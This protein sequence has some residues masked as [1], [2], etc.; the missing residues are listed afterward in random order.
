M[1]L[2]ALG[3]V[4]DVVV[5]IVTKSHVDDAAFR[6]MSKVFY[7][8]VQSQP[9]LDAQHDT[10]ASLTLVGIQVCRGSCNAEVFLV[11]FNNSF[12]LIENEVGIFG[13]CV[14]GLRDLRCEGLIGLWLG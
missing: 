12:Y 9:V 1:C 10:L 8:S 6:E 13:W 4:A 5:A 11:F 3:G 14:D 2:T 7:P